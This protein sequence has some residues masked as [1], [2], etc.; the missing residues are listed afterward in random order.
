[1]FQN[2]KADFRRYYDKYAG[3]SK[4]CR[5]FNCFWAPGFQAIVGYRACR[6]LISKRVPFVHIV[7]Q[8]FIEITTGISIPPSAEIGK[9]L[10][11]EHF[12]GI[13]I[14]AR[15]RM[16]DFCTISHGVTV[17]NKIP[18]GKSPIIG[19]NV[20]LCAGAKILG[21]IQIGSNCIVGAN[22]VVLDNFSDNSVIAGIPAKLLK[23]IQNKE[24]YKEFFYES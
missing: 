11:I 13:V 17:G 19:N 10:L 22:A 24:E 15:T 12:G 3:K 14:N 21:D 9:G 16:G 5:V 23:I 4:I 2:L 8:R 7:I 1:M 20:Y 6:W 18:G